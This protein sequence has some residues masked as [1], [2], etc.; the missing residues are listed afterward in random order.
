MMRLRQHFDTPTLHDIGGTI[1]EELSRLPLSTQ[2]KTGDTVAITVGSRGIANI[3]LII[4]SLVEEL[5]LHG[6]R[7]FIVPAMGSHGGA[8][9]EGQRSLVE[10]FGVTEAYTGAPIRAS[11]E[12]VQVGSIE[13]GVPVY[14]D[15]YAYEADHVA[16]VGRVKPHTD[17]SGDIESGLCKMMLIGLGKHRGATVYHQA[18]AHFSFDHIVRS[19]GRAV[20]E[21]C[22]IL[23]GLATVENQNDETALIRAVSPEEFIEQEKDLLILAKKWIPRLPFG[24]VDLLIIDKMG[25]NISGTGM[26]TNV[27]GRKDYVYPSKEEVFPKVT[28]IYVRDLTDDTKGNATG[29]GIA[30]YTHTQLV[31]R[32]NFDITYVNCLTGN[33]PKAAAVPLHYDTDRKVL[34]VA[35]N[36]IGYVQPEKAGVIRIRDTLNVREIMVSEVYKDETKA[37]DDLEII[38]PA[39]EMAFDDG[40]NLLPF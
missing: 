27:I 14:F 40:G 10:G 21:K 19:V 30:D 34:D 25:K 31:N 12:V 3:A 7:P 36:T 15:K 33:N 23:L 2:I 24:Q 9:A 1:R 11:M 20:I 26:D 32:I 38:E 13:H 22:R 28:R 6:A 16:V 4:K 29:I 17:F 5:K 37:R 8:T 39:R 18:F 35:L